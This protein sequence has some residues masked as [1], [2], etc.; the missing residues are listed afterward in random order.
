MGVVGLV[1][2]GHETTTINVL[3]DGVPISPRHPDRHPPVFKEDPTRARLSAY[4]ADRV[5]V[6]P[7]RATSLDPLLEAARGAGRGHRARGAFPQSA[8]RRPR[9]LPVFTTAA[10]P[11]SRA[12]TR[13]LSDRLRIPVQMANP[14]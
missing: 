13:W 4:D 3:D 5:F 14:I 7:R 1:N 9:D 12:S 2:I 6:A 11:A 8:S 10:A